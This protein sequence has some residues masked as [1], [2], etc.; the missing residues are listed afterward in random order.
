[1]A[2]EDVS[3]PPGATPTPSLA[4]PFSPGARSPLQ[5]PAA[6]QATSGPQVYQVSTPRD[7][8]TSAVGPTVA[9]SDLSAV[10]GMMAQ[11][12]QAVQAQ[13]QAVTQ[14]VS[15]IASQQQ[16]QQQQQQPPLPPV[17][18]GSTQS[19]EGTQGLVRT[20]A[21]A[22]TVLPVV[23]W[24]PDGSPACRKPSSP[25]GE[26]EWRRSRAFGHGVR[27]SERGWRSSTLP[28][29]ESSERCLLEACLCQTP[30]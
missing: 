19:P 25:P 9:T 4:N 29:S 11:T 26:L 10:M 8:P 15:V 17:A 22:V 23:R 1:M 28:L 24:I 5:P 20:P 14:L 6:T 7:D 18:A 3:T 2:Q 12:L 27:L 30:S 21:V 16:Q 13:T